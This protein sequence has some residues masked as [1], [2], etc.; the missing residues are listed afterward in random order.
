MHQQWAAAWIFCQ[1]HNCHYLISDGYKNCQRKNSS[2]PYTTFPVK[3]IDHDGNL[4]D[5]K[6]HAHSIY[7]STWSNNN[8]WWAAMILMALYS[9]LSESK[10]NDYVSVITYI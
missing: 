3:C 8:V 5:E 1:M 7:H 4:G 6:S 10:C 9:K 2:L